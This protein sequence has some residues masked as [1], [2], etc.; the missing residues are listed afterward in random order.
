MVKML[1]WHLFI[2]CKAVQVPKYG[3]Y[4]H[5]YMI[6]SLTHAPLYNLCGRSFGVQ[7]ANGEGK[8]LYC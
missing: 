6:A 3:R 4:I 2:S 1:Q 8:I 7:H 5:R